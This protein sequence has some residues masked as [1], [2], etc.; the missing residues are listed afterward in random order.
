M[1]NATADDAGK[2]LRSAL[3]RVAEVDRGLSG[4]FDTRCSEWTLTARVGH[5]MADTLECG[6]SDDE[7]LRVDVEYNRFGAERK[8]LDGGIFRADLCVHK[9]RSQESNLLFVEMKPPDRKH[10]IPE[11]EVKLMRVTSLFFEVGR[12]DEV[13]YE[14]GALVLLEGKIIWFCAGRMVGVEAFPG[15]FT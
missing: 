8:R 1:C 5:Y 14:L 11:A 12:E 7:H 2:E 4:D 13:R 9:R 10:E 3:N 6:G 15:L